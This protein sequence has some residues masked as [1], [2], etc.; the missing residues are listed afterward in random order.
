MSPG[1]SVAPPPSIVCAPAAESRP[2]AAATAA[3]R[4][5]STSTSAA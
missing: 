1:M 2:G 3:I 5:P 4:S